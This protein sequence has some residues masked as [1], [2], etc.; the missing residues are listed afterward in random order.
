VRREGGTAGPLEAFQG[1]VEALRREG[2]PIS[3]AET[4]EAFRAL[5]SVDLA[6]R[7]AVRSALRLTLA[8][9]HADR[10]RF[11]RAFER[12]FAPAVRT[13]DGKRKGRDA[14]GGA[15]AAERSHGRTRAGEGGATSPP[16]KRTET[17]KRRTGRAPAPDHGRPP[18]P[19]APRRESRRA[20]ILPRVRERAERAGRRAPRVILSK[21]TEP[22]RARYGGAPADRAGTPR[23]PLT[24][25][26]L[27]PV[28]REEEAAL[29]AAVPRLL[30]TLPPSPIRRQGPATR[31]RIW[32][33]RAM[34]H[35]LATEG[36]P[37]RLPLRA[38]RV[39]GPT[40]L[41]L[42]DVSHSVRRAA[43]LFLM[44]AAETIKRSARAKVLLFVD[45][46]VDVT[47]ELRSWLRGREGEPDF[48]AFLQG[49]EERGRIRIDAPSDYGTAFHRLL[50]A[51]AARLG[52]RTALVV[53]GD[54]RT[55]QFDPLPWAF[56]EV[57]GRCG[58]VLWVA[59]EPHAEWGTG[60]S[61]LE[62][63]LPH[64]QLVFEATELLDLGR[65]VSA[66]GSLAGRTSSR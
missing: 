49:L 40:P 57:A 44:L 48:A 59:P 9:T 46:P 33:R 35:S 13:G 25:T 2:V 43:G 56:E 32:M 14:G 28:T 36:V 55:N 63:Y 52:P 51:P 11:D 20:G 5:D 34:R 42:I 24:A 12:Y 64:C 37:F 50:N 17:E 31:G 60:D 45:R 61:A 26:R 8:K 10:E 58:H 21:A 7:A 66:L 27:R 29:A 30:A 4:V 53:L 15:E 23:T 41:F 47:G 62:A 18:S 19:T 3:A 1:F 22:E 54:G 39:E 16:D 6:N 65:A 38:P